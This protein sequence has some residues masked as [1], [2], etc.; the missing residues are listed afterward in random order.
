MAR[1]CLIEM[2]DILHFGRRHFA[3][4]LMLAS[5]VWFWPVAVAARL[6]RMSTV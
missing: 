4:R 3:V 2:P 6:G 5:D 1:Y